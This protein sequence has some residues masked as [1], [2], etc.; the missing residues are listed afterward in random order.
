MNEI[1][2]DPR[3]LWE[4]GYTIG[5]LWGKSAPVSRGG[6]QLETSH[7]IMWGILSIVDDQ[8]REGAGHKYLR[9]RLWHQNWIAVGFLN[10]ELTIVPRVKDAKFG[11]KPSAI[12]DGIVNYLDV[13]I[14][15]SVLFRTITSTSSPI[16][17][18]EQRGNTCARSDAASPR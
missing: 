16:V 1:V 6:P 3:N 9:E 7:L 11:R 12:G 17:E 4:N 14:L 13:R 10:G 5:E 2:Q 18:D 8:V 15:H